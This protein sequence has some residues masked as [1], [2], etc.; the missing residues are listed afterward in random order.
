MTLSSSLTLIAILSLLSI[1]KSSPAPQGTSGENERVNLLD[2]FASIL[3]Q[4]SDSQQF[5]DGMT[6][7][8]E[9]VSDI[10][11]NIPDNFTSTI[12]NTLISFFQQQREN[13]PANFTSTIRA[14]LISVIQQQNITGNIP[15]IRSFIEDNSASL[16]E[17]VDVQT[18]L[19]TLP[20]EEAG[21]NLRSAVVNNIP[22]TDT[23]NNGIQTLVE[24]IPEDAIDQAA[25]L[26][27][28]LF[29]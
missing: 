18:V 27:T 8:R 21:N 1:I 25:N 11:E 20:T 15:A 26:L 16:P 10:Q 24:N 13:M 4:V 3:G 6:M 22:D 9:R 19:D 14:N 23:I 29:G 7:A 5:K 12:G 2:A 28:N 17:G